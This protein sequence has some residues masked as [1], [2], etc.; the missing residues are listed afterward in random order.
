MAGEFLNLAGLEY[1]KDKLD[2]WIDDKIEASPAVKIVSSGEGFRAFSDGRIAQWG[3]AYIANGD[4]TRV[5]FP[6]TFPAE[7]ENVQCTP[8]GTVPVSC[9]AKADGL[10]AAKIKHDGNGG[11]YVFW[12]ATGR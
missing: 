4:G 9:T 11:V 1:F 6:V 7:I 8:S 2:A 5:V 12:A 10:G 3:I